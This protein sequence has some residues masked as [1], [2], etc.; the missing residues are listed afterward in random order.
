LLRLR[1]AAKKRGETIG[2]RLVWRT[3]KLIAP[4]PSR[5]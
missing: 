2:L 3:L 4:T 5:G 1:L